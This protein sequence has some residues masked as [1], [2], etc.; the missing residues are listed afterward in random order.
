MEAEYVTAVEGDQEQHGISKLP[1]EMKE[2]GRSPP[3]IIGYKIEDEGFISPITVAPLPQEMVQPLNVYF[4]SMLQEGVLSVVEPE[5]L[6]VLSMVS[7]GSSVLVVATFQE[8]FAVT[9]RIPGP[10]MNMTGIVIWELFQDEENELIWKW[11]EFARMPPLSLHEYVDADDWWYMSCIGVGDYLCFSRPWGDES[12]MVLA[13][14]LRQEFWQRLPPCKIQYNKR[15][16]KK[17]MMSFEPKLNH[18]Q[19]LGKSRE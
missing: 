9:L 8:P 17:K 16:T 13:Y 18:Y 12:A 7:F 10:H 4:V 11:K 15:T 3:T 6:H 14:N 2:L 5:K 19:L 1:Q